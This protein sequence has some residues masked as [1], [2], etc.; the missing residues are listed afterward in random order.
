MFCMRSQWGYSSRLCDLIA[1]MAQRDGCFDDW[2]TWTHQE[3]PSDEA[4]C[5]ASMSSGVG[6]TSADSVITSL[7]HQLAIDETREE[8][9]LGESVVPIS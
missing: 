4:V 7:E 2:W 9:G 6:S 3:V 8:S 5:A 1:V